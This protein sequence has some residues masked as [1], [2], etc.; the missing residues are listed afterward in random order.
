MNIKN[1]LNKLEA[2]SDE[3]EP[4]VTE[5][6]MVLDGDEAQ[7]DAEMLNAGHTLVRRANG[8]TLWSDANGH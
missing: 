3:G 8:F 5:F 6:S 4:L 1:R 2:M 7:H